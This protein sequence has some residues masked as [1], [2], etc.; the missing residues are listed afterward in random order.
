MM[1]LL[2]IAVGL[3][4]ALRVAERRWES[5][6]AGDA[7][8]LPKGP[9]AA[10]GARFDE[11]RL[12]GLPLPVAR[13]LRAALPGLAAG[14]QPVVR[15]ARFRQRGTFN[16]GGVGQTA[17]WRPFDA[18]QTA[19]PA[20]LG[21]VWTARIPALPLPLWPFNLPVLVRDSL[22]D[23][24]GEMDAS[25][26]GVFSLARETGPHI[27][28][29][30]LQRCLAEAVWLPTALLPGEGLHWAPLGESS[31][32][33]TAKSGGISA[34]LE[35]HF[36]P[37]GLPER[38]FAPDRLRSTTSGPVP[39]PWEGRFSDYAEREGMRIPL[40]GEVA[41]LTD[42]GRLTY[43]RGEIVDVEVDS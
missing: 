10:E 5:L 20:P 1:I 41:W 21:F 26:F 38:V 15:V 35:F 34:S 3:L 19:T 13:Y 33:A 18:T 23:G 25:V 2:V 40:K 8:R 14:G 6:A 42:E 37:D 24:R 30:A 12:E 31:A 17:R 32:L 43:W 4:G 16:L 7:D 36:G 27:A 9:G 11:S 22:A 28:E 39:T 29:A